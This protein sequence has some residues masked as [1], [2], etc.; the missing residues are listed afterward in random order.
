MDDNK[1]KELNEA[2][3]IIRDFCKWNALTATGC[4]DCPL[5]S[6]CNVR[7]PKYWDTLS[8]ILAGRTCG[9]SRR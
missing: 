6:N 9:E 2:I 4:L 7:I 1:K 5:L 8:D 3:A